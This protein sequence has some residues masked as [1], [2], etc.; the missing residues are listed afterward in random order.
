MCKLGPQ[1][2]S[3]R[4]APLATPTCSPQWPGL[5]WP[6]SRRGT[7][8]SGQTSAGTCIWRPAVRPPR[9]PPL[10]APPPPK[11]DPCPVEH[12][13]GTQGAFALPAKPCGSEAEGP[14]SGDHAPVSLALVRVPQ[15]HGPESARHLQ[16]CARETHRWDQNHPSHSQPLRRRGPSAEGSSTNPRSRPRRRSGPPGTQ[17]TPPGSL[18]RVHPGGRLNNQ[19]IKITQSEVHRREIL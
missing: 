6:C 5:S 15:G 18:A 1:Q 19:N 10:P 8:P 2:L 17:T 13:T 9:A 12:V 16:T 4:S 11:A 14:A 7:I 3:S